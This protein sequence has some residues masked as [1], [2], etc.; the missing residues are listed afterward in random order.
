M[1]DTAGI[2][3]MALSKGGELGVDLGQLGEFRDTNH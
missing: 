1:G 2:E 3:L